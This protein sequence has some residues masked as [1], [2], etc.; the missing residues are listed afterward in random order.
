MKKHYSTRKYTYS[1]SDSETDSD[2]DPRLKKKVLSKFEL[3]RRRETVEVS[4]F[5]GVDTLGSTF[6]YCLSIKSKGALTRS[7]LID[8]YFEFIPTRL[9]INPALD[10]C[11]RCLC[12]IYS[13]S[14]QTPFYLRRDVCQSYVKAIKA[15]RKCLDDPSLRM[16]PETLCSALLLNI[17]EVI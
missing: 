4:R 9:G 3:V 16:E 10:E 5:N 6:V 11:I 7:G 2:L 12:A 13:N 15:L 17:F 8:T 14:N 1:F